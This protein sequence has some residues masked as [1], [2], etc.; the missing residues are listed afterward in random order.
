MGKFKDRLNSIET[1]IEDSVILNRK[2][3]DLRNDPSIKNAKAVTTFS[4]LTSFKISSLQNIIQRDLRCGNITTSEYET[5][6][7]G[8]DSVKGVFAVLGLEM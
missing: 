7:D 2:L 1:L 8:L 4:S 5:L 6:I 3:S